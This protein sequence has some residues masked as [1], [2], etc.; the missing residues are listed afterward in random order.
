MLDT[1]IA[2]LFEKARQAAKDGLVIAVL[3]WK[4]LNHNDFTRG[5][6]DKKVVFYDDVPDDLGE[7]VGFV[8]FTKYVSHTDTERI[9]RKKKK[10]VWSIV[11]EVRVIRQVLGSLADL[12][13]PEKVFVVG[14]NPQLDRFPLSAFEKFFPPVCAVPAV[15]VVDSMDEAILDFLTTPR[16]EQEM[17]AMQKFAQAFIA[18]AGA[19]ESGQVGKIQLGRLRK[20]YGIEE[21]AA[22]L[23]RD[24]W[25]IG[26]VGEGSSKVGWYMETKTLAALSKETPEPADPIEYAKLLV[27]QE[28]E[29]LAEYKALGAKLD[30]IEIAKRLLAQR[31]ELDNSFVGLQQL[32]EGQA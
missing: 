23:V 31:Q 18:A 5:L 1:Q 8:L 2:G 28:P 24:G 17:S 12:L 16:E 32:A 11:V 6:S 7:T 20:E 3:G 30:K 19:N 13:A 10:K 9:K 29:V 27:S 4:D 26:E 25:L 22:K 14:L 15:D 21:S